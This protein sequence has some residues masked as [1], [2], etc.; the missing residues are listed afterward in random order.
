MASAE[1]TRPEMRLRVKLRL[2]E[3][4]PSEKK[5]QLQENL[6]ARL[7]KRLLSTSPW[8]LLLRLEQQL[9]PLEQ[10]ISAPL[11]FSSIRAAP[12]SQ[13]HPDE[14]RELRGRALQ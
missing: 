13:A 10:P 12:P 6:L 11:M 3:K 8:R 14:R 1:R 2:Q 9:L 4:P 7:E 5:M